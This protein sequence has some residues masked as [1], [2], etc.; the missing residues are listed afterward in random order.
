M[1]TPSAW[2][3]VELPSDDD[4]LGKSTFSS[5]LVNGRQP[6]TSNSPQECQS[7]DLQVVNSSVGSGSGQGCPDVWPHGIFRQ[8]GGAESS[9]CIVV[10]GVHWT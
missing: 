1:G 4:F 8:P 7:A 2:I 3:P 5:L 6:K 9:V 10:Y